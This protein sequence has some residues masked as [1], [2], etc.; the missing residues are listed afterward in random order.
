MAETFHQ[1]KQTNLN[2][3][4]SIAIIEDYAKLMEH[5]NAKKVGKVLLAKNKW[6]PVSNSV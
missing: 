4:Y 2:L 3:A 5:A 1:T 6:K